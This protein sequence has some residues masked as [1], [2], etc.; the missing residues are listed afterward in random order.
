MKKNKDRNDSIN[1]TAMAFSL[2]MF[3]PL[4]IPIVVFCFLE[5]EPRKRFIVFLSTLSLILFY[6]ILFFHSIDYKFFNSVWFL[7]VMITGSWCTGIATFSYSP[8]RSRLHACIVS[9]VH[10]LLVYSYIVLSLPFSGMRLSASVF[11]IALLSVIFF[12]LSFL[13]CSK[14]LR[15]LDVWRGKKIKNMYS[16]VISWSF[17][18]LHVLT[19]VPPYLS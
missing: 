14:E 11:A 7:G 8:K 13:Y 4:T 10:S 2:L 19:L 12:V 18:F 17:C 16:I 1:L 9:L 15:D 3:P 5:N 6:S